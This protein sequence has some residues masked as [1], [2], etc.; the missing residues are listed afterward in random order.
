MKRIE[1]TRPI[2]CLMLQVCAES[3]A[4]DEEI[5]A[6]C[7]RYNQSGTFGGW[8]TVIRTQPDGFWGKGADMTPKQC[9]DYPERT[10]FLVAC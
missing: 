5:L 10:H 1:I 8:A 4:T 7:N 3:D 2:I 6:H 9:A